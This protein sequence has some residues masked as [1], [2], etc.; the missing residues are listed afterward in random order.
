M[1]KI[2]TILL[3][4]LMI[5][6]LV[7][8]NS[9]K[10][11]TPTIEELPQV[12]EPTVVGGYQE[13]E[14]KNLTPELIEMFEKAFDGFTGAS[15]TP[16][17]L[18]ATQVVAGT[19]YKFKADGTK[20][21]NPIIQGTYYV[22]INKDL[23]GNISVLDIETIEEHEIKKFEPEEELDTG[24]KQD[25]T[26]MSFW[27]V[28][29]DQYGNEL[30]REALKYGTIP[31]FKGSYPSGFDSWDRTLTAIKGNTYI[32]ARCHEVKEKTSDG[33]SD[34]T[35]TPTPTPSPE[36]DNALHKGDIIYI[37]SEASGYQYYLVLKVNGDEAMLV[38]MDYSAETQ[39]AS[40]NSGEYENSLLDTACNTTFYGNLSSTLQNAIVEKTISLNQ[41]TYDDTNYNPNT[42]PFNGEL[43]SK[44]TLSTIDRKVYALDIEDIY[45]YLGSTYS[46]DDVNEITS[47]ECWFRSITSD[48]AWCVTGSGI[49]ISNRSNLGPPIPMTIEK[50]VRPSFVIDLTQNVDYQK[51]YKVSLVYFNGSP[52]AITYTNNKDAKIVDLTFNVDPNTVTFAEKTYG[53]NTIYLLDFGGY[54]AAGFTIAFNQLINEFTHNELIS[55]EKL[56]A[57][58]IRGD[59]CELDYDEYD[60]SASS[61]SEV[62]W[63]SVTPNY[64]MYM[65]SDVVYSFF[66]IDD[67]YATNS[68]AYDVIINKLKPYFVSSDLT[69]KDNVKI[70]FTTG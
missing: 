58:D 17:M 13:V 51:Q 12:E 36:E 64:D 21:T 40:D 39:F 7:G 62:Q 8:C 24:L 18:E 35:P 37:S 47:G 56:F 11:E 43:S 30:Q 26:N 25:I 2:L 10:E 38:N 9:S 45:G 28:F 46:I 49:D 41:Y 48:K 34:P 65:L 50:S 33:G 57:D 16:V 55:I 31:M 70:Y 23:D 54:Y 5:F 19:N 63:D 67:Y 22:Y 27:V 66:V 53:A 3:T 4:L 15:Y 52:A 61:W 68:S 14:D 1:K 44:T 32:H 29:Y 69:A 42:H 20:T 59:I 6:T 60:P